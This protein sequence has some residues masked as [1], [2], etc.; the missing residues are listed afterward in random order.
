MWKINSPELYTPNESGHWI[1]NFVLEMWAKSVQPAWHHMVKISTLMLLT[2]WD[3]ATRLTRHNT[4]QPDQPLGRYD[5]HCNFTCLL[6]VKGHFCSNRTKTRCQTHVLPRSKGPKGLAVL[7]EERTGP[8][9]NS[10]NHQTSWI[11]WSLN[12]SPVVW[13]R[14]MPGSLLDYALTPKS[15]SMTKQGLK[16]T[17]CQIQKHCLFRK[18]I[19]VKSIAKIDL[20]SAYYQSELDQVEKKIDTRNTA[21]DS[22]ERTGYNK[23]WKKVEHF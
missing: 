19:C 13:Q 1:T 12:A 4:C 17:H 10:E 6:A 8:T 14:K 7:S 3:T 18:L 9:G 16:L 23:R 20:S 22:T 11:F 5:L 2:C 21:G 15:M